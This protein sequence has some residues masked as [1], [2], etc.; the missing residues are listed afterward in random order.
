M[1]AIVH[2]GYVNGS[3]TAPPSKSHTQRAYAGALLHTGATVVH[4]AGHSADEDAALLVIQ[5][6]GAKVNVGEH[7]EILSTGVKPVSG[8]I[9]CGESGLAARLFTPVAAL[10]DGN[11]EVG[12]AGSLL[13][14]PM[15]G[16][17][18][19][20]PALNVSVGGFTGYLPFSVRGPLQGRSIQIN[21]AAGSQFLSGLLFAI[22]AAAKEAV[23][24]E[25]AN[26][27]SKPYIDLTLSVL[28]HFGKSVTHHNYKQFYI[29][30]SLYVHKEA[31]DISIE[32]DWSSAAFLLVAGAIAGNI[33]VRNVAIDSTQA[34]RAILDVLATAGA[35]I[36]SGDNYISV[37][38]KRLQAFDFD[39]TDS[40]DL[41]P[42]LS[43]LAACCMGESSIAGV[44]RLFYKES[45]RVESITEMLQDFAVPFSVEDDTLFITGVP[46]LQGTVIDAYSDHR[47][48][49]AAAV[50]ALCANGPVEIAGAEA[51][52]K[53]YPA[54]FKDLTL[55]GGKCILV[56]EN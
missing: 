54:F 19:V 27:K 35:E 50:G 48:V 26:L 51:V 22:S 25:V 5:Q 18:D 12:G 49:M 9:S 33:V 14:R 23:T 10:Y 21:A 16:F 17:A 8:I 41:F 30:P 32:A 29:D 40:P 44:H 38:K 2:A 15:D 39:A 46:Q 4:N 55:C 37:T 3:I 24:I 11:V 56:Y 45:N 43:V 52:N 28:A 42:I 1:K 13:R 31:I 6:L 53:S 36:K 47:I 20:L 7:I 34:D